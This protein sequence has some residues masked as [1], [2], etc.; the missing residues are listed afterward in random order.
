MYFRQ[1]NKYA[2]ACLR[3]GANPA[4]REAGGSHAEGDK[5]AYVGRCWA[6]GGV[7]GGRAGQNRSERNTNEQLQYS[8]KR[9]RM[10]YHI[11][12]KQANVLLLLKAFVA[13]SHIIGWK[14]DLQLIVALYHRPV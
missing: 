10:V 6:G 7:G 4:G 12:P 13:L 3:S 14:F 9:T 5:T 2:E 1:L 8:K 11:I